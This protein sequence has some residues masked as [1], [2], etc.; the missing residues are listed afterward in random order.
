MGQV[1]TFEREITLQGLNFTRVDESRGEVSFVVRARDIGS[2]S[3]KAMEQVFD[4]LSFSLAE[5]EEVRG[6]IDD[7]SVRKVLMSHVKQR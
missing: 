5:R 1:P 7:I 3:H 6:A 4:K 2:E